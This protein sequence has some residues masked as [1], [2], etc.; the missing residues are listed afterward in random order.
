MDRRATLAGLALAAGSGV[1]YGS[2]NV[3]AKPLLLH[4]F[5]KGWI[6]YLAAAL[7]LSPA[8]RGLRVAKG[9]GWRILAMGLVGGGVA[10]A[11]LFYGLERTA[12]ADAGLLLTLEL[13]TTAALAMLFLGERFHAREGV[14]LAALLGAAAC[15]ALASAGSGGATTLAG[16]LLVLGAA[17][18]WGIDNA[19]SARLVGSYGTRQLIA[20]KGL[21]GGLALLTAFLAVRAPLPAPGPA[22]AMAAL[23]IASIA[24]SSL[25]FYT[26]LRRV[27]AARTSAMNVATTG[28]VGAAGG[29]LLLGERLSWLHGAAVALLLVGA[30][31]LA[32]PRRP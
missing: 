9:D 17:V 24:L 7:L 21:L 15:V 10:P 20:A 28:L 29:A 27:G 1:L 2:I 4:P 6:A 12:A 31:L 14:G 19:V 22:L 16:A 25:L 3:L 13:V 23:G 8:L 18:A 32:R 26:A 30:S 5:A 11:L